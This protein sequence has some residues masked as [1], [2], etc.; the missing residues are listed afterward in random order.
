MLGERCF[1]SR[2]STWVGRCRRRNF[3]IDVVVDVGVGDVGSVVDVWF[4]SFSSASCPALR[5]SDARAILFETSSRR[6]KVDRSLSRPSERTMGRSEGPGPD[7]SRSGR[8]RARAIEKRSAA[9]AAVGCWLSAIGVGGASSFRLFILLVLVLYF[10]PALL[11]V[12]IAASIS[13]AEKK[14]AR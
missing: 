2:F 9:A 10:A 12:P 4:L 14:R 3:D 11:A 5:P 7:G 6:R 1:R 8:R 13:K